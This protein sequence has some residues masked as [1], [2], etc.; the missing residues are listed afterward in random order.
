MNGRK[1]AGRRAARQAAHVMTSGESTVRNRWT[2]GG[3]KKPGSFKKD[4]PRG[5]KKSHK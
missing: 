3:Y 2:T 5:R 1:L 4:F